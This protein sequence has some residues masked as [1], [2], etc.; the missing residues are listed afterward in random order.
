M[1]EHVRNEHAADRGAQVAYRIRHL[2]TGDERW[3]TQQTTLSR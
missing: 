1:I 3:L 2:A